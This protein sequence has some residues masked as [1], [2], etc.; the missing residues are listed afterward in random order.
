MLLGC[1]D[2]GNTTGMA[3][4]MA[5]EYYQAV[6]NKDFDKAA[7]LFLD[8]PGEPR[9]KWL[10]QLRDYNAKLGDLQDYKLIDKE[11]DTVYSGSRYVFRYVTTYSKSPATETL[12][13][14]D[15]VSNYAEGSA[16]KM[17]IQGVVVKSK[18]L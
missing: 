13:L 16:N 4:H 12:I 8:S 7:G 18:G 15:G 10:E 3:E 5:D 14:F 6:K 1:S 2:P 9:A 17:Q 11:V